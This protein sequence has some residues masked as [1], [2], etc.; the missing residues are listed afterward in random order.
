MAKVYSF[1]LTEH[2]SRGRSYPVL[3]ILLSLAL[4]LTLVPGVS[5]ADDTA[6]AQSSETKSTLPT[7]NLSADLIGKV[8]GISPKSDAK[9]SLDVKGSSRDADAPIVAVKGENG[10]EQRFE[11][12]GSG[13][14]TYIIRSAHTG[15]LIAEKG[16]EIVQTGMTVAT[17]DAQR[18]AITKQSGGYI[19]TNAATAS[20]LSVSKSLV[21]P[22]LAGAKVTDAQV[23]KLEER[24]ITLDGYY[25]FL[26]QAGNAIA[27]NKV[28][29]KNKAGIILKKDAKDSVGR[30][31][32]LISSS[33]GYHA[34][35]NSI[36]F[37]AL[38]IKGGSQKN[39]VGFVQNTYKKGKSQRFKL[40]PSGDGWYLLKSA[41]GSYVSAASDKAKAKIVTASDRAKALK[42]RVN[43]TE[44]STG[45]PK[46]DKKLKK[47]H[48]E[49]GAKGDTMK[50]SFNYIVKHYRHVN[51]PNNFKG[52]W[53][54][55]YAW[56]M[57]S[58]KHGHCKNF[59][60]TLCV[61]FRSYGYDAQV[62][63]GYVPSRSRGWAVHGWVEATIEGKTY[64]FDTDLHVQLG[65]RGW[66][67][68]TYKNAPVEYRIE[69][70]W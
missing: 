51:H 40:V 25:S 41:L 53:I 4:L 57:V 24:P 14:N 47:I 10:I 15:R 49:I 46:L 32:F 11:I 45:I 35:K 43:P 3:V 2:A 63:T 22:V 36:S 69:K 1:F 58:K 60:A 28:S 20:R 18:W 34:I 48:K 68:R 9:L 66:Y 13:A 55:R 56:Y 7:S 65:N 12:F 54:S 29:L 5:F 38:D 16:G 62:V 44:Y 50:K 39:G 6:Q 17:D 33:N 30:Q 27:L 64:I 52:D 8:I 37:K 23:F 26:T 67:K 42:V 21:K 61:F 31:F 70:R 19:F 59:A